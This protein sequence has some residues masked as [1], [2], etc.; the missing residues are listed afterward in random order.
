[1][2]IKH[3]VLRSGIGTRTEATVTFLGEPHH[4][5]LTVEPLR[6]SLGVVVGV[7]CAATDITPSKHAAAEKGK[8]YRRTPRGVRQSEIIERPAADLR[9]MQE[10]SR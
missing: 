8:A 1:M 9:G 6:D 3:G 10:D 7:T 4:F 5:D 2:A